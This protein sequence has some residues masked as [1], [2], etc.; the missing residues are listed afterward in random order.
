M[1][2]QWTKRAHLKVHRVAIME[3]MIIS[4][5]PNPQMEFAQLSFKNIQISV[6]FFLSIMKNSLTPSNDQD[7]DI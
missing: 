6:G 7:Q 5:Y 1:K 3:L 2:Q 4:Q